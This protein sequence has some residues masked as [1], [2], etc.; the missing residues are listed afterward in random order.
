MA[1]WLHHYLAGQAASARLGIHDRCRHL[2][3]QLALTRVGT[4]LHC[5]VYKQRAASCCGGKGRPTTRNKNLGNIFGRTMTL[6]YETSSIIMVKFTIS[7][8][9]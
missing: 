1:C 4:Y 2:G 6:S 8:L 5:F 7:V 3:R 9:R